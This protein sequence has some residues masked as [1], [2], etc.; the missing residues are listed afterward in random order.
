MPGSNNDNNTKTPARL[1]EGLH[2]EPRRQNMHHG[3]SN[4]IFANAEKLRQSPTHAEVIMWGYLS[5]NKLGV[6][7]RRQHPLSNYIA[8]FYCHSLKLV[9][10]IDGK[11]HDNAV[12]KM[13]DD[14]REIEI[15][16][17][18]IS[19]IR[20][21]NDEVFKTPELVLQ[22]IKERLSTNSVQS[23]TKK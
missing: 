18:G 13:N 4:L 10:E 22:K 20:F 16:K 5:G 9:I 15:A 7:F 23:G 3:A 17:F 8:D 14:L 19:I 11:I 21:T 2:A 1:E 6:K 12:S